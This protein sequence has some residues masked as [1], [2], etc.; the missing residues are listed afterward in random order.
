[1]TSTLD[2]ICWIWSKRAS[3]TSFVASLYRLAVVPFHLVQQ[4]DR[5]SARLAIVICVL[6]CRL[7]GQGGMIKCSAALRWRYGHRL[8]PG[9][10]GRVAHSHQL[11]A[12]RLRFGLNPEPDYCYHCEGQATL[13]NFALVLAPNLEIAAA[14]VLLVKSCPQRLANL[15][16]RCQSNLLRAVRETRCFARVS[17]QSDSISK[18]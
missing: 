17:L 4:W 14:T 7:R 10:I 11:R 13:A 3:S 12:R 15:P 6:E 16:P 1:M 8:F 9:L 5:N 2:D 18:P